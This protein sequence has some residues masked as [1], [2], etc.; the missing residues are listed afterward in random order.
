MKFA[1]LKH[2]KLEK[3]KTYFFAQKRKNCFFRNTQHK[4]AVVVVLQTNWN[5]KNL[6]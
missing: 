6:L 5:V 2:L 1:D 3:K 4:I